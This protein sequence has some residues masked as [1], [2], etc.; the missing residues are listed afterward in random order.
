[1]TLA[2]ARLVIFLRDDIAAKTPSFILD[3]VV[4]LMTDWEGY[5]PESC[6]RLSQATSQRG[7][8]LSTQP[9]V[10]ALN[11]D[12]WHFRGLWISP[13][14]SAVHKA[15]KQVPSRQKIGVKVTTR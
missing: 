13:G 7:K 1:M 9:C 3:H 12:P 15:S 8:Q 4:L 2:L 5:M 14:E 6:M 11:L 10:E